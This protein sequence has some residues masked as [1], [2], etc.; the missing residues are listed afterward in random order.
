VLV[1]GGTGLISHEIVRQLAEN[2]DAVYVLNRGQTAAELPDRVERL[3]GDR[4]KLADM[5]PWIEKQH[6]DCLID[7][8]GF[9][10][11]EAT[12]L[13]DA[14]AGIV[15]HVLYCSTVDVFQKPQLSYPVLEGAP[16]LARKGFPYAVGKVES[17]LLLEQAAGEGAFEL[18][19]LRPAQTY[20]GRNHG[21]VH[22]LGHWRYQL[23]RVSTGRKILLHGDGTS[24][25]SACHA[26]DV[27]AAFAAAAHEPVARGRT[28]NLA[29]AELVTWARYWEIVADAFA[30][31]RPDVVTVPS[32]ILSRRFA[33][34]ASWLMENFRFNNVFDSTSAAT[35]LGFAARTSLEDGMSETARRFGSHWIAAGGT[36]AGS[37]FDK[38]TEQTI[39]WWHER[40]GA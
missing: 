38:L 10:G 31:P 17:E 29:S 4:S 11:Q 25:W 2:G 26:R 21:P 5:R 13:V 3:I 20:G 8:I 19:L 7:M 27:G 32:E 36:E 33:G 12:K 22:P 15:E 16:R 37:S 9:T 35:D 6:F 28:Y 30:C 34:E 23:W 14:A 18:T 24:L 1:L 39:T 40:V